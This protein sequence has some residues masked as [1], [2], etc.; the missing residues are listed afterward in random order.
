MEECWSQELKKEDK[1]EDETDSIVVG[2]S[3][4]FWTVDHFVLLLEV[5]LDFKSG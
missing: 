3:E 1:M 4:Y 5:E 2:H